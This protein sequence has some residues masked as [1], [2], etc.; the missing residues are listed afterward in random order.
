MDVVFELNKKWY[1]IK[2]FVHPLWVVGFV[3]L[4]CGWL[5]ICP[6]LMWVVVDGSGGSSGSCGS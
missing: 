5:E 6:P 4:L 3:H 2:W 1:L